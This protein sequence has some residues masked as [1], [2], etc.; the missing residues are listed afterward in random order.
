MYVY[1]Y[2]A[3]KSVIGPSLGVFKVNN[4]AKFVFLTGHV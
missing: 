1:I 4:W 2:I 3:V